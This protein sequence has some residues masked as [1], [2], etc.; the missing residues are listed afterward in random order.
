MEPE[1]P[2]PSKIYR[3]LG[4]GIYFERLEWY[5]QKKEFNTPVNLLTRRLKNSC[6]KSLKLKSFNLNEI[7]NIPELDK[8]L[9]RDITELFEKLDKIEKNQLKIDNADE[10]KKIFLEMSRISSRLGTS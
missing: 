6:V 5:K 8:K 7:I 9:K 4:K 2:N 10:F 3:E 1:P